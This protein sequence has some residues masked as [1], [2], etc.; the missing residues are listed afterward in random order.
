MDVETIQEL[1]ETGDPD[2]GL[3][4]IREY[5]HLTPISS[6]S[7]RDEILEAKN[8]EDAKTAALLKRAERTRLEDDARAQTDALK[9]RAQENAMVAEARIGAISLLKQAAEMIRAHEGLTIKMAEMI[10][11]LATDLTDDPK[12]GRDEMLDLLDRIGSILV[13]LS[14]SH[15]SASDSA[16]KI[17]EAERL[18][19]GE[20]T[21]ILG[22]SQ[23][24]KIPT[25]REEILERA[26][27]A[28]Q[29]LHNI[30]SRAKMH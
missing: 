29:K 26:R 2:R 28:Q 10:H 16:R 7:L 17:I 27:E 23:L 18:L 15:K 30:T 5:M 3:P 4:S 21:E 12:M 25:D 9:T 13:K 11:Q 14:A 20:P 22:V 24:N 1:W 19:L 6:R 8:N